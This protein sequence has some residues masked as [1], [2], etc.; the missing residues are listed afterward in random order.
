LKP[1]PSN[2]R[3]NIVRGNIVRGNIVRGNIA[4]A[5]SPLASQLLGGPQRQSAVSQILCHV[6]LAR[7]HCS[8]A[9]QGQPADASLC[10]SA[11]PLCAAWLIFTPSSACSP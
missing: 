1:L 7:C 2:L 6:G 3:G 5:R 4:A 9:A 11:E 10:E 8:N